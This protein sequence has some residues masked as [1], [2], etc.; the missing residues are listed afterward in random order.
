MRKVLGLFVAMLFILGMVTLTGPEIWIRRVLNKIRSQDEESL[1]RTEVRWQLAWARRY[2]RMVE[3]LMRMEVSID[4]PPLSRFGNYVIVINHRNVLDHLI[5]A[6]VFHKIGIKDPRWIVKEEMRRAP[7]IGGSLERAGFA[8]V[9]RNKDPVDLVRIRE[10][11]KL[12]RE[13]NVSVALYPEGTRFNG[14]PKI[15]S[16]YTAVREPKVGG[17]STLCEELPGYKVLVICIDWGNLQD[18]RT[19]WD[20]SAYVGRQVRLHIWEEDNPVAEQAPALLTTIWDKME[21]RLTQS[22]RR[23]LLFKKSD[24]SHKRHEQ[25]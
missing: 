5:A 9:S 24:R 18:A 20:G 25:V 6:R 4:A 11:A 19:I 15:G 21:Q 13:D 14:K 17:F 8:F 2:L 22:R 12:A 23:T 1:R 3:I 16:P 10:M 7:I